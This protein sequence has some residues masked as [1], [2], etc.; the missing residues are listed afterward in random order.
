MSKIKKLYLSVREAGECDVMGP[1][2]LSICVD[3]NNVLAHAKSLSNLCSDHYLSM[4]RRYF[5]SIGWDTRANEFTLVGDELVVSG[6]DYWIRGESVVHH[7]LLV[8]GDTAY[9]AE[10][11]S[12]LR[13]VVLNIDEDSSPND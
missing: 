5:D 1:Q 4:A 10:H 2:Y 8:D 7:C 3:D 6:S 11:P 9:W 12:D 13:D